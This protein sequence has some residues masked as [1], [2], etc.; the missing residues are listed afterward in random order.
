MDNSSLPCTDFQHQ[1]ANKIDCIESPKLLEQV[2]TW[3]RR[4][5][6]TNFS[7]KTT[8][9]YPYLPIP[10]LSTESS[11][12]IM[13]VSG[14]SVTGSRPFLGDWTHHANACEKAQS[15]WNRPISCGKS[16]HVVYNLQRFPGE[17]A[18]T[19]VLGV[20]TTFSRG[21]PT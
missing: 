6:V 17:L 13:Q 11:R 15:L 1:F 5:D 20:L 10:C 7:M 9:T 16:S 18:T 2:I 8:H 3:S 12:I 21:A 14:P 4:T 19:I